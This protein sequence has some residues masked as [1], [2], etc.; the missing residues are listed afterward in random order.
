V[1]RHER[2]FSLLEILSVVAVIGIIALIAVPAFATYR[3]HTA[4]N[5][6][7][8]EFRAIFRLVRSRAIARHTA[9]AVKF[10]QVGNQWTYALHDDGDG[11]GVRNDD[12][13]AG[14]DTHFAPPRL[15][16]PESHLAT[17]SLPPSLSIKDPDG[18]P[19]TSLSSSVQFGRSTLCSFSP[20]G[21]STS[22]TI[23]LT[24]GF[25]ELWCV[26]VYGASGKVR[27]LRY[28]AGARTWDRR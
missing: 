18:D 4:V 16:L 2:G 28:N 1:S 26:R 6:A 27:L 7:A 5:E 8:S 11:D 23:Y 24:D 15:I 13:D 19:L 10:A 14:I 21:E 22:G 17:I 3:R 20:S 25:G 12:I 9:S